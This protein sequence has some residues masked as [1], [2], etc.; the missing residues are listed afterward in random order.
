MTR[1][2]VLAFAAACAAALAGCSSAVP[3]QPERAIVR[4]IPPEK[5][6]ATLR[7]MLVK[8]GAMVKVDEDSFTYR[9]HDGEPR[10][11]RYAELDPHIS[12]W[13]AIDANFY[14]VRPVGEY[15]GHAA[16]LEGDLIWLPES[17]REDAETMLDALE[18][19]KAAALEKKEPA[20]PAPN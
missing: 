20:L 4:S 14:L 1:A 2:A 11:Y 13:K 17:Q 8:A 18:S 10:R 6:R 9:G 16:G 5:A 12:L 15:T 7:H 3:Y 19:L